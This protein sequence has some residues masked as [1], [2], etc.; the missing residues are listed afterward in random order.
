LK[1]PVVDNAVTAGLATTYGTLGAVPVVVIVASHDAILG[2]ILAE[3]HETFRT[4]VVSAWYDDGR[5]GDG[6]VA[7][8]ALEV[9][10]GFDSLDD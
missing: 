4:R 2:G 6:V 7:D 3:R 9:F 10:D 5:V 8:G 1:C